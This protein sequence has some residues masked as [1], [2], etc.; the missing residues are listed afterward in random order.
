MTESGAS[1]DV[2]AL[3]AR[4]LKV[5][6]GHRCA[7]PTCRQVPIELAHIEPWHKVRE[8]S[9]ENMIALCPTCHTRFDGGD[10]DR[11]SMRM[12]KANLTIINSRYGDLERRVIEAFAVHPNANAIDLPGSLEILLMYLMQDGLLEA[13]K[14]SSSV[15]ISA[16][17][18]A[19]A[20]AS[21]IRYRLTPKGRDFV[22]RWANAAE[23]E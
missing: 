16:G 18:L 14:P 7:I 15:S 17:G 13:L 10:I 19:Q 9:F 23:L 8:H 3:L 22:T 1:R 5:E 2:P 12:Y 21:S 6:A 11:R 4:Q 20:L